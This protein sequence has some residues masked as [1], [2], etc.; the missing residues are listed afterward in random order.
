MNRDSWVGL[1]LSVARLKRAIEHE[2]HEVVFNYWVSQK[3]RL[4]SLQTELLSE[5][6]LSGKGQARAKHLNQLFLEKY[7]EICQYV[8]H[9]ARDIS[10]PSQLDA[11]ILSLNLG[12]RV[13]NLED[14]FVV[15]RE[16]VKIDVAASHR[17]GACPLVFN[18]GG[19]R[20]HFEIE[21]EL[22]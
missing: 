1:H 4:I 5:E 20:P 11:V 6:L 22:Q 12:V 16:Q 13:V 21:C 19:L 17:D 18:P 15:L 9:G 7:F 14:S 2:S 3:C 8:L 10:L